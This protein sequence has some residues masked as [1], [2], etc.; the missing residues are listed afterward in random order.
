MAIT[1]FI[2]EK[3]GVLFTGGVSVEKILEAE[4]KLGVHFSE[5]YKEFL[6][7]FGA[8]SFGD[9]EILGL[10]SSERLDVVASTIAE[11]EK[12]AGCCFQKWY[13]VEMTGVD[14][15]VIWQNRK[16]EVFINS[17]GRRPKKTALSI[18]EYLKK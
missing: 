14:G 4:N 6:R 12:N 3:S 15:I 7:E 18:E 13:I 1:E 10:G 8:A 11:R 17:C 2:K 9:H 5:E 16:G